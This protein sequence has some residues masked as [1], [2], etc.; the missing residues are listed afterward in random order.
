MPTLLNGFSTPLGNGSLEGDA[1]WSLRDGAACAIAT[2][3]VDLAHPDAGPAITTD[4]ADASR[5]AD[6]SSMGAWQYRGACQ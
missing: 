5:P 3:G 4:I 1:G 2:G 6:G